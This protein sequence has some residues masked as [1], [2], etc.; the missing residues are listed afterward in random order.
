[1][2]CNGMFGVGKNGEDIMPPDMDRYFKLHTARV[3]AVNLEAR[4]L[5]M[6]FWMI[7]GK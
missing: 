6:D 4:A 5:K 3:V 1:M 2:A 7:S